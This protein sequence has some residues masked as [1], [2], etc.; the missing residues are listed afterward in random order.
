MNATFRVTL[1]SVGLIS[2]AALVFGGE[3]T[4][5]SVSPDE[6]LAK[7]K[8]GN[9]RFATSKVSASKPTA[10]RRAETAKAQHPF[11]IVLACADQR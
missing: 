2:L 7:L 11:A 5:T 10:A 9:A 1:I 8:E 3:H 6:A 4:I